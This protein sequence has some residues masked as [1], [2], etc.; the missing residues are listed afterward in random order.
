MSN[1]WERCAITGCENPRM[2]AAIYCAKRMEV[3]AGVPWGRHG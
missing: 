1:S 3:F 2:G